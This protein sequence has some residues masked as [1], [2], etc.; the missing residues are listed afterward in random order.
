MQERYKYIYIYIYIYIE[1][2]RERERKEKERKRYVTRGRETSL[3]RGISDF[4]LSRKTSNYLKRIALSGLT[5]MVSMVDPTTIDV[6]TL[7]IDSGC[8]LKNKL[9]GR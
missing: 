9:S 1:R 2:E 4:S 8:S 7:R 5:Y 3:E 6:E